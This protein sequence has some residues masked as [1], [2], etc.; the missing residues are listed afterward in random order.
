ML[1]PVL[2]SAL[3]LFVLA[4][5]VAFEYRRYVT[6]KTMAAG[7][8]G[9]AVF[10]F[11]GSYMSRMHD[12]REERAWVVPDD[13][14]AWG[15]LL[16]AATPSLARLHVWRKGGP[17]FRFHIE[18]RTGVLFRTLSLNT[19]KE[20]AFNVQHLDDNLR[21]LASDRREAGRYFLAPET[22]LALTALFRD[23]FAQVRGDGDGI[24]AMMPGIS[25]G[26]LEP[27]RLALFFE[28]LR[29]C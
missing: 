20:A 24:V 26:D 27:E 5:Y 13:K 1:I 4:Y 22:E 12:G 19:L 10:R 3:A 7:L 11:G 15:S 21:L 8:G 9:N 17:G 6:A 23:G 25:S 2:F 16:S 28:H 14:M 29:R 18:P